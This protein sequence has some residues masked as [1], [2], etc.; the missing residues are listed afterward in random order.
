MIEKVVETWHRFR[1]GEL[2]G[3]AGRFAGGRRGLLLAD[4]LHSAARTLRRSTSMRPPRRCAATLSTARFTTR[5]RSSGT[6]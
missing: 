3:G 5:R 2:L 6:T 4:R 1:A